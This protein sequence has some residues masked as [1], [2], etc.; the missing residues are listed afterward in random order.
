MWELAIKRQLFPTTV[1]FPSIVLRLIVTNSLIVLL[2]PITNC[3]GCPLNFKSC[4]IAAS[5][6]KGYI[7]L[8][9]P[10]LA[11]ASIVTLLWTIVPSPISTSF[12]II[13]KAP[14]STPGEIFA[15]G[16]TIADGWI[17]DIPKKIIFIKRI[18][19][20]QGKNNKFVKL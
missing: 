7:I 9:L 19:D 10:I 11:P 18:N 3:E 4:G 13:E 1:L 8:F 12:S 16:L 15:S 14:T 20:Q 6:E 2:S 17:F 5:T